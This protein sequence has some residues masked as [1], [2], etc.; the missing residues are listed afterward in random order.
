MLLSMSLRARIPPSASA[1]SRSRAA[2]ATLL[3][4]AFALLVVLKMPFALTVGRFWA[5]DGK[6]YFAYAWSHGWLDALAAEHISY[7]SIV[8]NAATLLA[9]RLTS[10]ESAPVLTAATA[11]VIQLLPPALLASS[12]VPWLRNPFS[13]ALAFALVLIPPGGSEI[14]LNTATSQFHLML[15]VGIVLAS[16]ARRGWP[17]LLQSGSVALASLN[18]PGAAFLAPLFLA[19]A[20][21]DRSGTRT[22]QTALLVFGALV[23]FAVHLRAPAG[24]RQMGI[25]PALL[26]TIIYVKHILL[27]VTGE[28]IANRLSANLPSAL[29]AGRWPRRA[30]ILVVAA[31][32]WLFVVSYRTDR[33]HAFWLAAAGM[34]ILLLS[35][36]GALDKRTLVI[37]GV[38]GRYAFAPNALFS[39]TLLSVVAEGGRPARSVAGAIIVA[40]VIAGCGDYF[41]LPDSMKQ[42]PN[43]RLEVAAWR[44]DPSRPLQ[45]WPNGWHMTLA[46]PTP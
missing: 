3:M 25:D 16:D 41:R 27:P 26:A 34:V 36:F 22:M 37:P 29:A 7:I 23:Q 45:I 11:L 8:P 38:G 39:L 15:C 1:L 21:L 28:D 31:L 18:G 35:Y 4:L 24:I 17:G 44:Q 33:R 10:L 32:G 20:V 43:W 5:E 9:A 13:L 19:R 42:G 2:L 40:I 6:I 46:G 30:T 12:G 14:W